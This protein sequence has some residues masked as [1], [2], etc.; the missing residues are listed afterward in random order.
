M[1]WA[2]WVLVCIGGAALTAVIAYIYDEWAGLYTVFLRALFFCW[3]GI[4]SFLKYVG[5]K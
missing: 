1:I 2:D 4:H 5:I 3:A